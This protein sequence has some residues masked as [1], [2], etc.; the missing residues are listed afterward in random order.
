MSGLQIMI[1]IRIKS[2]DISS[3][4]YLHAKILSQYLPTYLQED[5]SDS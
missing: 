1:K 5:V 4:K 2:N 3:Q